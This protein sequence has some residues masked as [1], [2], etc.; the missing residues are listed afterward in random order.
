MSWIQVMQ[1]CE[2][3]DDAERSYETTLSVD[4]AYG[5]ERQ[6]FVLRTDD[7]S[8]QYVATTADLKEY[9]ASKADAVAN[10]LHFYRASS[11]SPRW[12]TQE[13]ALRFLKQAH[14][15]LRLVVKTVG[16][17]SDTSPFGGVDAFVYD[18]EDQ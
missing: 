10:E 8:F 5:I 13:Q 6:L 11:T 7:D 18:S 9:P 14:A 16:S 3:V 17:T 15:R 4:A 12:T 1:K 2:V